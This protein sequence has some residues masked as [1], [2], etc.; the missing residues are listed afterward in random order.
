M[1]EFFVKYFKDQNV[2]FTPL[3]WGLGHST[4]CIPIIEEAI[5]SA[6]KV[7]IA[8]DGA[9]LQLLQEYFPHIEPVSYTHLTL[10][11]KPSG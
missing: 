10:P 1:S 7:F 3:N 8:S 5:K 4:R 2:L 6:K 9:A 11:T